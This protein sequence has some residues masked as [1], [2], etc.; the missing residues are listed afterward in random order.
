MRIWYQS[1]VDGGRM[2]AYFEGLAERAG[3]IARP[4]VEVKEVRQILVSPGFASEEITSRYLRDN[5]HRLLG[6]PADGA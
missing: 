3:R 6:L 2:P 1:L 4:A 5:A